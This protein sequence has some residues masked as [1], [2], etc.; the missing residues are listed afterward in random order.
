[1]GNVSAL[2]LGGG[3]VGLAYGPT[4]RDEAA[5]TVH[6]A[7]AAGITLIDLA[8]N[9]GQGE[10]ERL[11][12][13]VYDGR[14]PPH[15]G[16]TTKVPLFAR[17]SPVR[18]RLIAGASAAE[19][20]EMIE[21]SFQSSLDRLRV[22]RVDVLFA[23]DPILPDDGGDDT[24]GLP[25]R[26]F[27]EVVRPALVRIV[28]DGRA[29]AWGVSATGDQQA[30]ERVFQDEQ[31]P[32]AA[33]IVTNV[34]Q[35]RAALAASGDPTGPRALIELAER[36]SIAVLGIAPTQGGA[37]TDGFDRPVGTDRPYARDF[38][39]AVHFRTLAREL[40]TTPAALAHR[41][42]LSISGVST[43]LIGVKNRI[44][45]REV[46]DAEQAGPL[47]AATVDRIEASVA[48]QHGTTEDK[49]PRPDV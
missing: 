38:E 3:G 39:R 10:A 4:P 6:E 40:A 2:G 26:L 22:K 34:L 9:Y 41:Y 28:Q 37:L 42:A 47:D 33:Q 14:I 31:P 48:A 45:L 32:M 24:P 29:R 25:L 21:A 30:M 15:V 13:D 20:E 11:I 5:A 1:M 23:H 7:V 12:G 17:W 27:R 36:Y 35:S 16:L 8:P 19:I 18:T 43:V 44:E 49:P 46:L